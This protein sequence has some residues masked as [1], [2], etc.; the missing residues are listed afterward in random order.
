LEEVSKRPFLWACMCVCVCVCGCGCPYVLRD[1]DHFPHT[2][3]GR[4]QV[5][6]AWI[7]R[8]LFAPAA[9]LQS[10]SGIG[11]CILVDVVS[12]SDPSTA[13]PARRPVSASASPG[14]GV[15]SGTPQAGMSGAVDGAVPSGGHRGYSG[16]SIA[17]KRSLSL[18][19]A[20][21]CALSS[22]RVAEHGEVW[23]CERNMPVHALLAL[24][25]TRIADGLHGA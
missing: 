24:C 10:G 12:S 14:T 15:R 22:L 5:E 6:I 8:P 19:P 16:P 18:G 23:L 1:P 4:L 13:S 21:A 2:V 7:A 3:C 20:G 11:P 25:D 17:A 9:S